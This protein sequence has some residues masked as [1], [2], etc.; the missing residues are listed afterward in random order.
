[1]MLRNY[2]KKNCQGELKR[3]LG[4]ALPI[5]GAQLIYSISGIISALMIAR[6]GKDELATN[7]LVWGIYIAI[8]SIFYGIL[9]SVS[10]LVAQSHGAKNTKNINSIMQQSIL[11]SLCITPLMILLIYIAPIILVYTNQN[12][13]IIRLATPFFYSLMWCVLP[14]NIMIVLEQFFIAVERTRF[15]LVINIVR[16]ILE[17]CIFY[18]LIFG[19]MG[20]KAFG[21]SGIGYGLSISI[22]IVVVIMLLY[23]RFAKSIRRFRTFYKHLLFKPKIFFE[24]IKVGFPLGGMYFLEMALFAAIALMIGTFGKDILAAHQICY[25]YLVFAL[26]IIFGVSQAATVR[27]GFE[28]GK[29]DKTRLMLS[30][31]INI[32]ISFILML[33][34]LIIYVSIPN[35]IISLSI[36]IKKTNNIILINYTKKFLILAGILQ[37]IDSV[38]LICIGALRGLKDTKISMYLTIVTYWFIASPLA[39]LIGIALGYG[40]L[41]VWV[42]L[43]IGLALSALILLLRFIYIVK[44]S[45]LTLILVE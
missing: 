32:A 23:I 16:V 7:V 28:M 4:I 17:I 18:I 42:G 41:G 13:E 34:I 45:K 22:S 35:Y 3:T 21:L 33:V 15:L 20:I 37:L 8:V 38:R 25:Q 11:L 36:D 5:I 24:L 39:Y 12:P 2:T 6:I 40:A 1:M 27:V 10:I 29:N 26:A 30:V 9:S 31:C 44:N 14:L 43:T 19:K